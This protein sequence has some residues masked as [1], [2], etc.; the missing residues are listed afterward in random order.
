MARV[1]AKAVAPQLKIVKRKEENA[2]AKKVRAKVPKEKKV[3]ARKPRTN[4]NDNFDD[5]G[6]DREIFHRANLKRDVAIIVDALLEEYKEEGRP[7]RF[8]GRAGRTIRDSLVS[9]V[10]KLLKSSNEHLRT[11]HA[12]KR[13][14]IRPHHLVN[15]CTDY[16]AT[17]SSMKKQ[18]AKTTRFINEKKEKEKIKKQK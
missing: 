10:L 13:L 1:A 8:D 12:S 6:V 3:V 15:S 14:R 7:Y 2:P 17:L 18:S 16:Y 11:P 5:I 9:F 4:D